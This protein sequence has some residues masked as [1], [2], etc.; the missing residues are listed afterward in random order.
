[1]AKTK[2]GEGD[3]R[4]NRQTSVIRGEDAL[5]GGLGLWLVSRWGSPPLRKHPKGAG[6]FRP[7]SDRRVETTET[8]LDTQR[9]FIEATQTSTA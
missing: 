2:G 6:H 3:L 5:E 9:V 4:E 1:M 7:S 8:T